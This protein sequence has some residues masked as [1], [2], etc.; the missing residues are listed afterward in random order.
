VLRD[1]I[2]QRFTNFFTTPN[3]NRYQVKNDTLTLNN[4]ITKRKTDWEMA[5]AFYF[6]SN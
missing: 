5:R 6:Y 1:L 3:L 4:S 2:I